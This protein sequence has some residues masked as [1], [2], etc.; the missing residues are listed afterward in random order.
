MHVG[1]MV[2]RDRQF[3]VTDMA[4]T[5]ISVERACCAAAPIVKLDEP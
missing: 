3:D 2:Y 4:R 1:D 5:V